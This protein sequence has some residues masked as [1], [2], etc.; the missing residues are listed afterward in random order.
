MPRPTRLC[1]PTRGGPDGRL[2]WGTRPRG[3]SGLREATVPGNTRAGQPDGKRH[4]NQTTPMYVGARVKRWG[5]S[6]PPDWQQDG[7]GKPHREQCQ[8][9]TAR[10]HPSGWGRGRFSPSRSGSA[11]RGVGAIRHQEEW[12]SR[13]VLRSHLRQNPA[14]RPSTRLL[15]LTRTAQPLRGG[16]QEFLAAPNGAPAQ[17]MHY[18]EANHS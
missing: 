1:R 6:P 2:A 5:K 15:R 3:K 18:G 8:I 4:R 13:V 9:G 12:S 16:L 14:Y 11:A 17:E 10:R 7:H